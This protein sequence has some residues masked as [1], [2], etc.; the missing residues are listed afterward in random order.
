M[1]KK[2]KFE[3]VVIDSKDSEYLVELEML[4]GCIAMGWYSKNPYTVLQSGVDKCLGYPEDVPIGVGDLC[5]YADD[6]FFYVITP[7]QDTE[8]DEYERVKP[9]VIEWFKKFYEEH[10]AIF[11]K[12]MK[13]NLRENHDF[14]QQNLDRGMRCWQEEDTE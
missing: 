11:H 14:L 6:G 2:E 10:R 1:E 8:K 4:P 13:E 5:L 7:D 3:T 12:E 9:L